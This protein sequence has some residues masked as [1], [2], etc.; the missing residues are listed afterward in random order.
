MS[1][2]R[3]TASFVGAAAISLSAIGAPVAAH[4]AVKS[5]PDPA[6][7]TGSPTDIRNVRVN[8]AQKA[9]AVVTRFTNLQRNSEA[10]SGLKILIDTK[11]GRAGAEFVLVSGL[12]YGTD[13]QLLRAKNGKPI[14][15]P[16][17]CAHNA[18]LKFAKNTQRFTAARKC[19]GNPKRVRVAV[20][21]DDHTDGSHPIVDR[22]GAPGSYS[23][24]VARG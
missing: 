6:D 19:L 10:D 23:G 18:K 24:W 4:A 1:T 16:L 12:Q 15:E 17:G 11:P 7:A 9:V 22:L 2:I 14:G 20:R 5:F 21:M 13:Y 8:H 3:R